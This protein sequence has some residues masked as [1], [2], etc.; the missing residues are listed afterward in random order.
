MNPIW[1]RY[2]TG[3]VILGFKSLEDAIAWVNHQSK[4]VEW[5]A[6]WSF[7]VSCRGQGIAICTQPVTVHFDEQ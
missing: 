2:E 4:N 6:L 3:Q 7:R 5:Q 1:M